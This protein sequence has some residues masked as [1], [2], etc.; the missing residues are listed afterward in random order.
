ML[1]VIFF[2]FLV[3]YLV[4]S[5]TNWNKIV[6][7]VITGFCILFII[8]YIQWDK[9]EKE[10]LALNIQAE[11]YIKENKIKEALDIIKQS[12]E[13]YSIKNYNKAYIL[14]EQIKQLQSDDFLKKIL[15]KISDE[16]AKLLKDDKLV[17]NY[18]NQEYLNKYFILKLKDNLNKRITYL[19]ELEAQNKKQEAEQR[20][21][22]ELLNIKKQQ[23]LEKE[24]IS[25]IEK[26][27]KEISSIKNINLSQYKDTINWI[28]LEAR[29]F[30]DYAD[31]IA[32]YKDNKDPKVQNTLKQFKTMV[33][34]L[35]INEFPKLR[36]AFID[37]TD[38]N[39]WEYNID[40]IWIWKTYSTI[41]FIWWIYASN[42][43]IKDQ[44]Q[45]V[46]DTLKLLRFDK[47]NFKWYKYDDEYTYYEIDSL[48]D[49]IISK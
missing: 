8:A 19:S 23:E 7:A 27:N 24:N 36:K 47:I 4:W 14:E 44:Y 1:V 26:I 40:V 2:P 35:Q 11:T 17:K 41:E 15:V 3:P 13:I 42:K 37:L 33:S 29:L 43:N 20:K 39:M 6:K 22:Q 9:Y 48:D 31:L 34:N 12:K 38:K 18:I 45:I 21:Q 32:T 16:E 49:S 5:K 46:S 25:I 30:W 28:G 10:A